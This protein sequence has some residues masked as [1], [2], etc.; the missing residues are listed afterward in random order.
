ML[1][2]ID[3]LKGWPRSP[4]HPSAAHLPD[5]AMEWASMK[6]LSI[7]VPAYNH[8]RF[9]RR[10]LDSVAEITYPNIELVVIDDGSVDE[11]ME[12]VQDW[13]RAHPAV[14][15]LISSRPNRGITR[16]LNE[17]LQAATGEFVLPLASDDFL[18]PDGPSA[19]V[20]AL[21]DNVAAFGD[22]IVVDS[23]GSLVDESLLF[24]HGRHDRARLT[25]RPAMDLIAN[26][27]VAG[28]IIAYRR[29][30]VM[31]IGGYD[32][33]LEIEDLD[34]YLRLAS[35]GWLKFVDVVVASHRIHGGNASLDPSR[36]DRMNEERRRVTRRAAADFSGRE[37]VILWSMA[38]Y[39]SPRFS[40]IAGKGIVGHAA[41]AL[42]RLG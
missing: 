28:P 8:E 42:K 14:R 9:I 38:A 33:S 30:E 21:G 26:W 1:E 10:C 24:G 37:R 5:E 31:S 23:E 15:S 25:R 35:K 16:T 32:E 40:R 11:T 22:A 7:V 12:I 34:F 3:A 6:L 19:L 29:T 17:L 20:A 4:Y 36:F 13:C 2:R 27:S 41:R 18:L 39:S